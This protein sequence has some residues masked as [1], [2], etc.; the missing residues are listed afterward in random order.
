MIVYGVNKEYYSCDAYLALP[1]DVLGME[2]YTVSWYPSSYYCQIVVI[3]VED[4]TS[5]QVK[6]ST[7]VGSQKVSF[8]GGSY[9]KGQTISTT[10]QKYQILQLQTKG[11]LSGSSITS[12][13]K[14]GVLGGNQRTNIGSGG[15]SDHIVEQLTPVDTWGKNFITVPIPLRT[16]GDY[17]KF[18]A[19]EDNTQVVIS[20]GYSSTFTISQK[21]TFVQK[22]LPSSK[23][24]KVVADKPISVFQFCMSQQSSNEESDPM[25]MLVPPM[26]QYGA[27]YTFSTPKWSYGS[28][29]NYFMFVVKS[30]EKSGL[31]HNGNAFPGST[32]YHSIAGTD[33]VAGYISIPE[34]SHVI[35]HTSPISIF[36]GY[37]YGQAKYETYG[38]PSGMRMAPVNTVSLFV[39]L[40][41]QSFYP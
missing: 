30:S 13:K 15:S 28:Y 8:E 39:Y 33:Y 2:Y 22:T 14:V 16:T 41:S 21:G 38:F 24:T 31:R 36:G 18:V 32:S 7:H 40:V 35:R 26:E 10:L 29:S 3:G 5:V 34:G 25:L 20:G 37:L 17:F 23:Y 4:G 9:G 11:D 19:S 6:L 1:V 12:N 27:D